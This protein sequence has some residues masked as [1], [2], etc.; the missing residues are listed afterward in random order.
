[1][2]K[3]FRMI[4][5][6]QHIRSYGH[7]GEHTSA[8]GIWAKLRTQYNLEALDEREDAVLDMPASTISTPA[9]SSAASSSSQQQR[10]EAFYPFELPEEEFLDMM[11]DRRVREEGSAAS[12]RPGS[13]DDGG[14]VSVRDATSVADTEDVASSPAP[15][16]PGRGRAGRG[17]GAAKGR[18]RG[19]VAA[20]RA[21][22]ENK[23]RRRTRGAEREEE[24]V[25]Q[26]S[27]EGEDDA[28]QDSEEAGEQSTRGSPAT[29]GRGGRGRGARG[30]GRGGRRRGG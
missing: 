9:P 3:H 18:G 28:E 15:R 20:G 13:G 16:G 11:F 29:R 4:S 22:E 5:L 26:E 21:Q 2:H 7:V 19:G 24:E 12:S 23:A 14:D 8:P 1:M 10:A 25:K 17:G 6:S 30:R 27:E